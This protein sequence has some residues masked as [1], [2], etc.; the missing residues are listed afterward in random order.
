MDFTHSDC[1]EP[2]CVAHYLLVLSI[3]IPWH[4]SFDMYMS[5]L[6]VTMGVFDDTVNA[7]SLHERERERG[8]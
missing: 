2:Y 5:T 6:T 8:T 3:F 4:N 7:Q 1:L